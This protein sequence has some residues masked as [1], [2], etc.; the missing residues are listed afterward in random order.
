MVK[1]KETSSIFER[2]IISKY[3]EDLNSVKDENGEYKFEVISNIFKF[4]RYCR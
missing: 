2:R 3:G 4:K 1:S